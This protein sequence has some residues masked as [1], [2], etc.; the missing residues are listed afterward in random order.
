MRLFILVATVLLLSC[1]TG[2]S[3]PSSSSILLR[4]QNDS[5]SLSR[6][7]VYCADNLSHITTI[8]GIGFTQPSSRRVRVP[9]AC[10]AI[11]IEAMGHGQ[12]SWADPRAVVG[13]EVVCVRADSMM[14]L[15]WTV[16]C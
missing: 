1:A 8:N 13:S 11:Q 7:R 15:R 3:Y 9:P 12:S 2:N 10:S 6:V 14:R 5:W 4:I 16:G